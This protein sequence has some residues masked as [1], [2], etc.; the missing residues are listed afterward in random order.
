MAFRIPVMM[1]VSK[2]TL[3]KIS[4]LK[5]KHNAVI[6]AHNYQIPEVQDIADLLG[7]SLAL[8]TEAAKLD[9][10]VII[11]CGVNFM[12]ETA[13]ILSPDKTV[14]HPE[15]LARCPMADMVE[16]PFLREMKARYPD[17]VTVSYVNTTADVKAESDI[18]CTSGNA[19]KVIKSLKEKQ[20]I[21]TPDR[22][23]G[24]YTQRFVPEK[25]IIIWPGF[26]LVHHNKIT[27]KKLEA[28]KS[29]H[30]D[31]E[32]LVHPECT[33]EVIDYADFTYSTHGMV[34][35]A[36]K[37]EKKEFI[38]GTEKDM[39][40]RMSRDMPGKKFYAVGDAICQN[41]KRITLEKVV[42]SLET[43]G[44]AVEIPPDI[45]KRARIPL[46]RMVEIGRG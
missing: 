6:I 34:V 3:D 20:V 27:V 46:D 35:H 33:P 19:V 23:L 25:E 4:E 41:M 32:V 16:V 26:C 30:P 37:S 14:I 2:K 24:M 21:F 7:D 13:K 17:A 22:N 45:L 18:C 44:P 29:L 38:L 40:H 8:A 15:P 31:A 43:L 36:Q 28:L 12:A 9:A 42:R 1:L 39:V 10:D 5:K 11:F